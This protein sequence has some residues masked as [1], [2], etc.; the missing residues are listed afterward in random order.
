[1]AG[2]LSVIV[3]IFNGERFLEDCLNSL[4]LQRYPSLEVLMVDDGSTDKSPEICAGFSDSDP[5]FIYLRKE[6]G[7]VSSARNLGLA[8]ARG[9]WIAF[10]D[11]DDRVEPGMYTRLGGE[12]ESGADLAVCGFYSGEKKPGF[13]GAEGGT[14]AGN[15]LSAEELSGEEA[16]QKM[17][18][19]YDFQMAVW[20]KLYR[21][22]IV[23]GGKL[24]FDEDLTHGEDGL[25]LCRYLCRCRR[26]IWTK[27]PL[28]QYRLTEESAMRS[29]A[30]F[31]PKRLGVLEAD[32]RMAETVKNF[33]REAKALRAA[34]AHAA[35]TAAGLMAEAMDGGG[36]E[37]NTIRALNKQV[38]EYLPA[39]CRERAYPLSERLYGM[40]AGLSPRLFYFLR[41]NFSGPH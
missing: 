24:T 20:N 39:L 11:A 40:M 38:R 9:E 22:E 27:E 31:N 30:G 1:M 7:G 23:E 13:S 41:K 36:W 15:R 17:F 3:P 33:N 32:R 34:R 18:T 10:A 25:F 19:D 5:R 21:R 37:E 14:L 6:N 35:S 12:L 16:L 4:K 26:V 2:F 29:G 8:K 28:Y